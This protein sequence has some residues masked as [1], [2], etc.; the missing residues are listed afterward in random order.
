[1]TLATDCVIICNEEGRLMGLPHCC[2][3]CGVDFVGTVVIAGVAGEE[4]TDLPGEWKTWKRVF[5]MLW[6]DEKCEQETK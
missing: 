6:E 2:R 3:I 1:M 5:R 4:F